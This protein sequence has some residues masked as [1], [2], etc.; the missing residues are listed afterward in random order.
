MN[1]MLYTTSATNHICTRIG[2]SKGMN[3]DVFLFFHSLESQIDREVGTVGWMEFSY[4]GSYNTL[5]MKFPDFSLTF[6]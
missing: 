3:L 1:S 2:F 6:C 4:Q 5:Q